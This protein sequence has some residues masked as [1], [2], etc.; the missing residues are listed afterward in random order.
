MGSP[1]QFQRSR[2]IM[3]LYNVCLVTIAA[4]C[5]PASAHQPD[6]S[7]LG[8]PC[9]EGQPSGGVA[10][11]WRPGK[12]LP[13]KRKRV[14]NGYAD[15]TGTDA[16]GTD[17]TGTDA[18]IAPKIFPAASVFGLCYCGFFGGGSSIGWAG[19]IALFIAAWWV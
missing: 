19:G 17:A 1:I 8:P 5:V 2:K 13:T 12:R 16:T 9:G 10:P 15:A 6:W 18:P 4:L 3:F 14:N 11:V 7:H